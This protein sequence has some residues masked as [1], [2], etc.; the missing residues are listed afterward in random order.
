M[1]RPGNFSGSFATTLEKD[2]FIKIDTGI[3]LYVSGG[4]YY[5][6]SG[7]PNRIEPHTFSSLFQV[8]LRPDDEAVYI[9]TVQYIRDESNKLTSVMIRDDYKGADIHFKERFGTD[10]SLRKALLTPA[11]VCCK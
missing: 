2:F 3:I 5:S 1:I 11:A 7:I 10:K 8:E 4:T 6:A 9:G